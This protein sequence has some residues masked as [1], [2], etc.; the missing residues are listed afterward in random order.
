MRIFLFL[1]LLS[2]SIPCTYGY[3]QENPA[4]H[5]TAAAA[6]TRS[7]LTE[8]DDPEL[9]NLPWKNNEAAVSPLTRGMKNRGEVEV[10]RYTGALHVQ[11]PLCEILTNAGKLPVSLEYNGTGIRLDDMHNAIGL[12]WDLAAGGRITRIVQG[13]PDNFFNLKDSYD[14]DGFK[15]DAYQDR[16]RGTWDYDSQP[17]LYSFTIPGLSG[18]FVIDAELNA[19]PYPYM[20]VDIQID[21]LRREFTL[22]D[23]EGVCYAFKDHTVSYAAIYENDHSKRGSRK[24]IE[25]WY[26]TEIRYPNGGTVEI[27][28]VSSN[29]VCRY[30]SGSSMVTKSGS[31]LRYIMGDEKKGQYIR[32]DERNGHYPSKIKYREQELDFIY[33]ESIDQNGVHWETSL[34]RIEISSEGKLRKTICFERDT[35]PNGNDRLRGVYEQARPGHKRP[36]A[37]FAYFEEPVMPGHMHKGFDHWG[38]W[39]QDGDDLTGC[40]LVPIAGIYPE[41][42]TS[43]ASDL[44][45]TRA[46]SL[47]SITY[48]Q[49]G[50]REIVYGLHVGRDRGQMMM[51]ICGG[52][53]VEQIIERDGSGA[54]PAV[55]RYTYDG[56]VVYADRFNYISSITNEGHD[57]EYY[58]IAS[59]CLSPI[60][61]HCGLPVIYST[62]TEHLPNGSSV[63]YQYV[64]LEEFDDLY[65]EKYLVEQDTVKF[66]GYETE[67]DL[68]RTNRAW[69][70]SL[71]REETAFD[72]TGKV[73]KR[74]QYEYLIDTANAV[75]IPGLVPYR[76]QVDGHKR[77][78]L[79]RYF[80]ICCPVLPKT[81]IEYAGKANLYCRTDYLYNRHYLPSHEIKRYA[82]GMRVTSYTKY[83]YEYREGIGFD[84][85]SQPAPFLPTEQVIYR[86]GKVVSAAL[87][88]YREQP[89]RMLPISVLELREA[90][91][92]IDSAAFRI[93]YGTFRGE[94]HHDSRYREAIVFDDYDSEGNMTSYHKADGLPMSIVYQA[95]R[96]TPLAYVAHARYAPAATERVNEVWFDDFEQPSDFSWLWPEYGTTKSGVRGRLT[97]PLT[98]PVENFKPGPY[99]LSYW[100]QTRASERWYEHRSR[101]EITDAMQSYTV[102]FPAEAVVIDDASLLP[103]NATLNSQVSIPGLGKIS[104]TDPRGCTLYYE[105][106]GFGLPVRVLD[107]ERQP[108]KSYSYDHYNANISIPAL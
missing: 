12:G 25:E 50:S 28:Y 66:L 107:N 92:G 62:V 48:P 68:P 58:D 33:N 95:G 67:E 74:T 87:T 91:A 76:S 54:A 43:R 81:R 23:Q 85:G 34:N 69:G 29:F 14:I 16:F 7:S 40:P 5:E 8:G 26:L 19:H 45:R 60:S 79:A 84:R 51:R 103:P 100:Y 99:I 77:N 13:F 53:R 78:C 36:I 27:N 64:P 18:S 61:D 70:R 71:L 102:Q 88:L 21:T 24:S 101:I 89:D 57:T 4:S 31:T 41:F 98:I 15:K 86:N 9:P 106:N 1:L 17:D 72:A 93:S 38:Y 10:D 47:K 56:G 42:G 104:E 6:P 2:C 11:I 49:G 39:N 3:A 55:Y 97:T 44:E 52:L 82:D 108:I 90:E 46:Q 63:R 80:H 94:L 105:Y 35:F 73:V 83:R 20:P 22:F 37:S 75:R 32:E 30:F 59:R 65:S 96:T